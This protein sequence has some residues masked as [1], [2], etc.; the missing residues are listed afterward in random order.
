MIQIYEIESNKSLIG[1]L[2]S[3][4]KQSFVLF[5]K[6]AIG[7][8]VL[9]NKLIEICPRT[10]INIASNSTFEVGELITKHAWLLKYDENIERSI[11]KLLIL[12]VLSNYRSY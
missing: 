7:S 1:I 5:F 6:S 3:N 10:V 12:H 9:N 11:N 2:E 4:Y 8:I